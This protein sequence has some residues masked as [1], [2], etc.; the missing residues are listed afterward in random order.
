MAK[1]LTANKA[2]EI[3]HDKEVH[4]HPLTDKQRRFFGAIAGGAPVKA[5]TGWLANYNDGGSMESTQGGYTDIPFKYN[6]AWGG[7]FQ[8]GGGLTFLEP[9]SSKLPQGYIEGS[10]IPSTE[11]AMS[12]GGEDGEPAYLIPSFK[13]G[14]P[15]LG[16]SDSPEKEFQRTGEH[17]G[18]PFKT[19]QEADEWERNVRHPYVEKGQDIP[20]PLRRWGKDFQ[21]GGSLPGAVGFTYA[22]THSPAPS[23][24]KYAKKTTPSAQNGY[25]KQ[26]KQTIETLSNLPIYSPDPYYSEYKSN[27]E[28]WK[29]NIMSTPVEVNSNSPAQGSSYYG[30]D[31]P[32]YD[33]T[34]PYKGSIQLDPKQFNRIQTP[35]RVAEHELTH[36]A[37]DSDKYIP[38]WL[39]DNLYN[40]ARHP[41]GFESGEHQDR[42]SERAA[43][44]MGSRKNIIEELGL[45]KDAR[46]SREQFN[47]WARQP[48]ETALRTG[49]IPE[50]PNDVRETFLGARNASDVHNLLNMDVIPKQQDGGMTYYQHGLDWKPKTISK[51]GSIIKD[52]RGQWAHPGEITEIGSNNITMQGV[53]Y[54]VLGISD[55]GDTKMMLP[56]A[57]Y[58][59][60]GKKVTEIPMA[61]KGIVK[62]YNK[63]EDEVR[64]AV[65]NK[66]QEIF[67]SGKKPYTIPSSVLKSSSDV[68]PNYVCIRGVCGILT[69]AG[70]LPNEYFTNTSFQEKANEL[71]FGNPQ[72]DINL[73]KPGDVFQH[74]A[75]KNEQGNYYPSHAE[76]FKGWKG[77]MGEFY[78]YYDYYN[79]DKAIREYTKSDIQERLNRKAKN[80]QSGKQA[81]FYSLSG[82]QSQI[83][84]A[85]YPY[86][87]PQKEQQEYFAKTHTPNY[88]FFAP[89]SNIDKNSPLYYMSGEDV[90]QST[91]ENLV[92]L[93]NDK[94]LDEKLRK[95]LKITDQDLKK[96]KPLIYG[97][98]GQESN[99]DSPTGIGSGLKYEFENIFT[100]EGKSI[101]PG[102][103]KLSS[104]SPSVKKAFGIE[105]EKDL[106]DLKN[107]YVGLADIIQKS[108]NLTDEYV[109]PESHPNLMDK[110]RFERGLYFVNSPG[111]VRRTDDQNYKKALQNASFFS[112]L[113][114]EGRR[115]N[116]LNATNSVLRMDPGSYPGKVLDKSKELGVITNYE[117]PEMLP[118]VEVVSKIKKKNFG[119]E[120]T[121]KVNQKAS[122]GWLSQYK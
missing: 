65:L 120:L 40:T 33:V 23:E 16:P 2:K 14:K 34:Y 29:K 89:S 83:K 85:E 56:G 72:T 50:Q 54:P 110:D 13:Y 6:S 76:I 24:G 73:L 20:T 102:Q 3:L 19:W 27:V 59:F 39:G 41:E 55:E 82:E 113:T 52:D 121:K 71:G 96:I 122:N 46:I 1:K 44:L 17:L 51:N 97:V 75:E 69:D 77:D 106:L 8:N 74:L 57:D 93:F 87:L 66:A 42:L 104:I 60:K 118:G 91:K 62:K 43:M 86:N 98:I 67:S 64:K 35:D 49:R 114:E 79:K 15:I 80:N 116:I 119:G 95:E 32:S 45:P 88:Q 84:K 117:D 10:D 37:F 68:D 94:T 7:Q 99:F 108:A 61:Q 90:R 111:A 38:Q 70:F 48:L 47:Y 63:S 21:T 31:A 115:Q 11:R 92:N 105:K 103:V 101:G 12:I 78:D 112:G 5:E 28:D 4:G 22:R 100:P 81:Q 26:K 30:K 58:K 36:A 18:G 109:T 9:T 107:T 25:E 53:D